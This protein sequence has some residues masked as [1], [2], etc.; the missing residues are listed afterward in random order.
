M[1]LKEKETFFFFYFID[2]DLGIYHFIINCEITYHKHNLWRIQIKRLLKI[3]NLLLF[4]KYSKFSQTNEFRE[5]ID[6]SVLYF[7]D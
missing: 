2:L 3:F 7:R 1:D 5:K 6:T 4:Y